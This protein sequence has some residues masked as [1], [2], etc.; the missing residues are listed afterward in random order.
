MITIVGAGGAIGNELATLLA[1]KN[2]PFRL[3]SRNVWEGER[4]HDRVV[5]AVAAYAPEGRWAGA[6]TPYAEI[7]RGCSGWASSWQV[8]PLIRWVIG[9]AVD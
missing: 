6:S 4:S 9:G 5:V 1:A 7:D 2:Q 3:V 8:T